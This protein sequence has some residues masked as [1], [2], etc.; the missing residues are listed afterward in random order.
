MQ[1]NQPEA[2]RQVEQLLGRLDAIQGEIHAAQNQVA[3]FTDRQMVV[4]AREAQADL[5]RLLQRKGQIESEL[6]RLKKYW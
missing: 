5:E 3:Q 4:E 2:K 1:P 6:A